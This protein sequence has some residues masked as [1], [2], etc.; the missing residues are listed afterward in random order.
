MVR[1]VL[2]MDVCISI[3]TTE[4]L[5]SFATTVIREMKLLDDNKP[6]ALSRLLLPILQSHVYVV[7][8]CL[9]A[10]VIVFPIIFH[11]E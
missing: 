11:F 5:P 3:G 6:G 1:D 8:F 10:K 4:T 7:P 9:P 2:K